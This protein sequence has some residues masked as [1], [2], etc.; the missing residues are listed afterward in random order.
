VKKINNYELKDWLCEVRDKLKPHTIYYGI[1]KDKD[2]IED[3]VSRADVLRWHTY[4]NP[5]QQLPKRD[6]MIEPVKQR[7]GE[8][9]KVF[10]NVFDLISHEKD[11]VKRASE[12]A[13]RWLVLNCVKKTIMASGFGKWKQL[14]K[15][16]IEDKQA[17]GTASNPILVDSGKMINCIDNYIDKKLTKN[18]KLG[19][20]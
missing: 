20:M 15:R 2:V 4:G 16:T 9:I 7:Q 5:I 17:K 3:G 19:N 11:P 12:M 13:G 8:I 6:A 10:L 14:S 1:G 18:N